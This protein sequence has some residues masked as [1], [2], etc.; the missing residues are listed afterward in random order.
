M[1]NKSKIKTHNT[2][3]FRERYMYP[4]QE[5]DLLLKPQFGKFF[6][7]KVEEMIRLIKLPVP[8][9]RATGHSLIYLTAGEANMTIGSETYKIFKDECLVVPAGQ[10]YA[11]ASLDIN[12]GY[13]CHFQNDMIS[14]RFGRQELIRDMEFLQ[15]WSNPRI[16]LDKQ[17]SGFVAMLFK[18][19]LLDYTANGLNNP[20]IL[21]SYFIALLCELNKASKPDADNIPVHSATISNKFRKLLF[22]HVRSKHLVSDYATLLNISPNHLNKTVKAVTGKSP[23]KWIDEAIV[24]EAKV[25]LYQSNLSI[26]AIAAELGFD[27]QSYFTRLFKKYEGATPLSFRKRIEKS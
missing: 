13:L 22:A 7:V 19:L 5:L 8:P 10:V 9:T 15:V 14:S 6:I 11:F 26:S 27:D 20:D 1:V 23:G 4:E 17:S 24:L 3:S 21:Q 16:S 12:K 2:V 25:L 18:R